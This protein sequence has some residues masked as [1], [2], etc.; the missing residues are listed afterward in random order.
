MAGERIT[1]TTTHAKSGGAGSTTAT[2][3]SKPQ[4]E[5]LYGF[6]VC[7]N[8]AE[9]YRIL[10]KDIFQ[11]GIYHFESE[12]DAPVVLD[13]GA[14]IGMS[15]LYFKHVYP[16]ARIT[17]F[18]PDPMVLPFLKTNI[19][20]NGLTDVSVV[21]AALSDSSQ[22]QTF[23]A[24]GKYS[25]TLSAHAT[26]QTM[27]AGVAGEVACVRLYDYLIEPV[28]FLKMNIEG[29]EWDVLR[30]AAPRL[31]AVRSMVVEYHHLPGLPRTLHK[32]LDLLDRCGFEYLINDFDNETNPHVNP[33]FI[34][35]PRSSYYLL[36]Y[37]QRRD[38]IYVD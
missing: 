9:N 21:E 37:A 13:G 11:K 6:S 29:A 19:E 38:T 17:A 22:S 25:S 7:V 26:P 36:I 12:A 14:N 20:T 35:T 4:I 2:T 33:P 8:D 31:G 1:M 10:H 5:R 34:L 18:E 3:G 32:I 15:T 30:D 27:S 28:D 16:D 24:D 23:Y